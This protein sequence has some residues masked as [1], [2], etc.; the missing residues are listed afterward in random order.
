MIEIKDIVTLSDNNRYI[1]AS[2]A[3]YNNNV[4]CLLSNFDDNYK[5][6]FCRY[7]N[8]EL[9]ES[10]DKSLNTILLPLFYENSKNIL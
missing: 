10:L 7:D 6:M 5:V 3:S 2:I 8:G 1:V 4:Y 9:I